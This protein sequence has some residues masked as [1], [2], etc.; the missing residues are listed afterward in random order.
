MKHLLLILAVCCSVCLMMTA[1]RTSDADA[2]AD[3]SMA[4]W[5]AIESENASS[6]EDLPSA[7]GLLDV[8]SDLF[9]D[10]PDIA[11]SRARLRILMHFIE[12]NEVPELLDVLMR[13][14]N[15]HP[16]DILLGKLNF[17][18]V[19][20]LGSDSVII[21]MARTLY[22]NHRTDPELAINFAQTLADRNAEG[23]IDSALAIINPI[24]EAG[25]DP[26][27]TYYK[28]QLYAKR[29]DTAAVSLTLRQMLADAPGDPERLNGVASFY[30]YINMPDSGYVYNVRACEA[31]STFGPALLG[32][33]QYNLDRGDTIA[34]ERYI[35][36]ALL[37][38]SMDWE[39][40]EQVVGNFLSMKTRHDSD[41]KSTLAFLEKLRRVHSSEPT[42]PLMRG[43]VYIM[44]DS[45]P[46][47]VD[48]FSRAIDLD[49][50]KPEPYQVLGRLYFDHGDTV[51]GINTM[52][53]GYENVGDPSFVFNAAVW[54]LLSGRPALGLKYLESI[55]DLNDLNKSG[56]SYYYNIKGDLYH[57]LGRDSDAVAAL[58][59]A[60][61]LDP[62]AYGAYNNAA[63]YRAIAGRDLDVAES[64]ARIAVS[65]DLG[66]PTYLD[67]YAWVLFKRKDF[68]AARIQIDLALQAYANMDSVKVRTTDSDTALTENI[69]A[70]TET[71]N[72]E[73]P[74]AEVYDHAGDIYFMI[75]E[76]AQALV[77]WQKALLLAPD[78]KKIKKKVENKTYFPDE[79]L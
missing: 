46:Q 59:S 28:A 47:A 26:G 53:R 60:I 13:S 64:Y 76:P 78:D 10:D 61:S 24:L 21:A 12:P 31:D 44:T 19:N 45:V 79:S 51:A 1:R 25:V 40:K 6:Q 3:A 38:S 18:Y 4:A 52:M 37:T 56:K 68:Q 29:A 48:D 43:L 57:G 73:A 5:L 35:E 55:K 71:G 49:P 8:A 32:V 62:T 11:A 63:Y 2:R 54:E 36:R 69:S 74:S 27:L 33:A 30:N 66:N 15:A 50:E 77:Y 17:K 14:T 72:A 39:I 41:K 75:G 42:I 34:F 58:D 7:L 23:D 65:G 22:E 70:V 16:E 67:T 9:P 20:Y